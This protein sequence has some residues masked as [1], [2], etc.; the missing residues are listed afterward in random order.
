[1]ESHA[2]EQCRTLHG[3]SRCGLLL[4]LATFFHLNRLYAYTRL[5]TRA[6]SYAC[7]RLPRANPT[8]AKAAT[9]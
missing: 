1:M 4:S 2:E 7:Q 9:G 3:K 6:D 5:A 8:P